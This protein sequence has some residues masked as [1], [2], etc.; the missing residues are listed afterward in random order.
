MASGWSAR[1]WIFSIRVASAPEWTISV[2]SVDHRG[3]SPGWEPAGGGY[4]AQSLCAKPAAKKTRRKSRWS[5]SA[6]DAM[7]DPK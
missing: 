2:A 4:C 3:S 7:A 5:R 1:Y 6:T